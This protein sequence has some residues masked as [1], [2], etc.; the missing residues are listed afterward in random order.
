MVAAEASF[1][2]RH[3][4]TNGEIC[5]EHF[6]GASGLRAQPSGD[7]L[8]PR[9]VPRNEDEIVPAMREP[10]GVDGADA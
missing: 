7:R 2:L 6:D 9:H 1:D 10:I 3:I 8:Q 5:R 4:R